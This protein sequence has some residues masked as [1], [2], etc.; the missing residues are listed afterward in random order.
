MWWGRKG[1]VQGRVWV[2]GGKMNA[3]PDQA[4]LQTCVVMVMSSNNNYADGYHAMSDHK[5]N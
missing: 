2:W 3:T 1:V 4:G 5:L